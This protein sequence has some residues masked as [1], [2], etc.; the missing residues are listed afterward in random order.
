MLA[1]AACAGAVPGVQANERPAA[2]PQIAAAPETDVEQI[3]SGPNFEKSAA[4]GA[5][6]AAP[7]PKSTAPT[8]HKRDGMTL[9]GDQE[10]TAFRS[11]TVEGEDRVHFEIERPSLDLGLDPSTAP[12][13]DW[14][15]TTDVLDRTVPDAMTP[16]LR[17]ST[18]ALSPYLGRPWLQL[19]ASGIV[20]R[21]HPQ[22]E[23][24]ERWRLLVANSRGETVATFEGKGKPPREITWDGR[25]ADGEPARPGLTYSYVLEAH[26]K[27]GNKRNFVGQGFEVPSY[28]L[29][30]KT[31]PALAFV[32]THAGARRT[33]PG[34]VQAAATGH[35]LES[36]SW[37]NQTPS[38]VPVRLVVTAR[39]YEQANKLA[40]GV[41]RELTPL[42]LGNPS[43]LQTQV[44]LEP[45]ASPA[46]MVQISP[47]P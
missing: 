2:P 31:G 5:K 14:G 38:D 42:L 35:V 40:T 11:L 7:E 37:L 47:A 23:N 6:S 27:A 33:G 45:D 18:A 26:D 39:S 25:A 36:A 34:A 12:G 21:F 20:A 17:G 46:G 15:S 8:S 22:V 29:Q 3:G 4:P 9:R 16:F 28:R 44:R 43:R 30:T 24:V 19:F 10:G 13:L 32:G 1:A 41:A